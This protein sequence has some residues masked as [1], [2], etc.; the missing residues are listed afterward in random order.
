MYSC[1]PEWKREVQGGRGD[2]QGEWS[3]RHIPQSHSQIESAGANAACVL[4]LRCT[5][6][7]IYMNN[8]WLVK[9]PQACR[10]YI[11]MADRINHYMPL[12]CFY[13]WLGP[14]YSDFMGFDM[15]LLFSVFILCNS[16]AKTGERY[17]FK[18]HN[19][20][21]CFQRLCS[22]VTGGF[23]LLRI[24]LLASMYTTDACVPIHGC[25][26]ARFSH[27]G[28]PNTWTLSLI[29]WC[30]ITHSQGFP[31]VHWCPICISLNAEQ[32]DGTAVALRCPLLPCSCL[33]LEHRNMSPSC[34]TLI[35]ICRIADKFA[36]N[37]YDLFL[38]ASSTF[39]CF[40]VPNTWHLAAMHNPF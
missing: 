36:V 8:I 30:Y 29:S 20:F 19:D 28:F 25:I 21:G 9:V 37:S 10:E 15:G 2:G 34:S 32:M 4:P 3:Q 1:Y 14:L 26:F 31:L 22:S 27:W 17:T 38:W 24:F 6:I 39:F 33:K 16:S 18:W 40:C 12:K 7:Y 5:A 23:V 35:L 11:P 13:C